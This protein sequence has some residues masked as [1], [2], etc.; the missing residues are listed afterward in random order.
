MA[1]FCQAPS[2]QTPLLNPHQRDTGYYDADDESA[3]PGTATSG[4][5]AGAGSPGDAEA[6]EPATKRF[7]GI[8]ELR[9]KL[10][11]IFPALSIGVRKR[12]F[13]YAVGARLEGLEGL[14]GDARFSSQRAIRQLSQHPT[15]PSEAISTAWTGH[16]GW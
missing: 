6:S 11:F 16:R 4:D 2:E 15:A 1:A 14:I 7:T 3:G 10:K 12:F 8:P 5:N 13:A 9:A